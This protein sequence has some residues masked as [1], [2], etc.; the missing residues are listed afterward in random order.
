MEGS[1]LSENLEKLDYRWIKFKGS[2]PPFYC[3][4]D[5]TQFNLYSFSLNDGETGA[6]IIDTYECK[7]C[8]YK[9]LVKSFYKSHQKP[10]PTKT[11][12]QKQMRLP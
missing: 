11:K 1:N 2:D 3:E 6:D 10:L 4:K 9:L 8:G 5:N 12:K 7:H